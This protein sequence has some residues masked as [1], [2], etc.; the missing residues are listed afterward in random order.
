MRNAGKS[1]GHQPPNFRTASQEPWQIEGSHSSEEKSR[2]IYCRLQRKADLL[3]FVLFCSKPC[4]SVQASFRNTQGSCWCSPLCAPLFACGSVQRGAAPALS[5][6]K[7]AQNTLALRVH[8]AMVRSERN[9]IAVP[10]LP[11]PYPGSYTA[12]ASSG[13]HKWPEEAAQNE[14][15]VCK[16]NTAMQRIAEFLC[17]ILL[18]TKLPPSLFTESSTTN[19]GLS[20]C[21]NSCPET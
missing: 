6:P 16:S 2:V 12:L 3:P 10:R 8:Q 11:N 21:F 7:A 19:S 13:S 1:V 4:C 20:Y 14:L 17:E 5:F 15:S 9:P 18:Q